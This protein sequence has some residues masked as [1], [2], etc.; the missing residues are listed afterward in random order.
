MYYIKNKY[1]Y[2]Y[3]DTHNKYTIT[4]TFDKAILFETEE[5]AY[6]IIKNNFPKSK[7]DY[8]VLE[9]DKSPTYQNDI[10]ENNIDILR[11]DYIES[12]KISS[13][14]ED[15]IKQLYSILVDKIS[16]NDLEISDI[17]HF[18]KDTSLPAD[19]QSK[20]YKIWKDKVTERAI[21]KL[22]FQKVQQIKNLMENKESLKSIYKKISNV[23]NCEYKP[24]TEIWNVL[25]EITKRKEREVN[26]EN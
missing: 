15:N 24:R 14:F 16:Q 6:N 8:Q 26:N 25:L 11:Y 3:K 4:S 7:R 1:G 18:V 2:L 13:Y 9:Y 19:K 23:K 20:V 12:L 17:Y 10:Q 5:K 22:E 21:N